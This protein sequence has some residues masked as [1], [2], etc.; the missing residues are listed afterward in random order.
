M[1]TQAGLSRF[2]QR[3]RRITVAVPH[4]AS[5]NTKLGVENAAAPRFTV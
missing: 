4:R 5:A 3:C 1:L 2:S